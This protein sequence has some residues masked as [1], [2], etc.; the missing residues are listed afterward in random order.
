MFSHGAKWNDGTTKTIRGADPSTIPAVLNADDVAAFKD[1]VGPSTPTSSGVKN[2]EV[3]SISG[4]DQFGAG[5]DSSEWK[6]YL[7]YHGVVDELAVQRQ[8]LKTSLEGLAAEED[9]NKWFHAR[10][11]NR[12]GTLPGFFAIDPDATPADTTEN[13][14]SPWKLTSDSI[15]YWPSHRRPGGYGYNYSWTFDEENMSLM[16]RMLCGAVVDWDTQRYYPEKH[17]YRMYPFWKNLSNYD[18]ASRTFDHNLDTYFP[19]RQTLP[20]ELR[21]RTNATHGHECWGLPEISPWSSKNTYNEGDV[22]YHQGRPWRSTNAGQRAEPPRRNQHEVNNEHKSWSSGWVIDT[23]DRHERRTYG[24][25]GR[26]TIDT[27][28][29]GDIKAHHQDGAKMWEKRENVTVNGTDWTTLYAYC[30]SKASSAPDPRY[31]PLPRQVIGVGYAKKVKLK[32]NISIGKGKNWGKT[33]W[34]SSLDAHQLIAS[35]TWAYDLDGLEKKIYGTSSKVSKIYAWGDSYTKYRE[36]IMGTFIRGRAAKQATQELALMAL[37]DPDLTGGPTFAKS[38]VDAKWVTD[39]L[40]ETTIEHELAVKDTAY[41]V[42]R[43]LAKWGHS[44]GALRAVRYRLI[45]TPHKVEQTGTFGAVDADHVRRFHD[46]IKTIKATGST[47]LLI[48]LEKMEYTD[49]NGNIACLGGTTDVGNGPAPLISAEASDNQ[50]H[51]NTDDYFKQLEQVRKEERSRGDNKNPKP[52]D[53][54]WRDAIGKPSNKNLVSGN[55]GPSGSTRTGRGK[56][57]GK[58]GAYKEGSCTDTS[59]SCS[60]LKNLG[61]KC[62]YYSQDNH[63]EDHDGNPLYVHKH[64]GTIHPGGFDAPDDKK[65]PAGMGKALLEPCDGCGGLRASRTT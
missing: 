34:A 27:G 53:D 20:Q 54:N 9:A 21:P 46:A 60:E 36:G 30:G 3:I 65:L 51:R 42:N 12:D 13:H 32:G 55:P 28:G 47:E 40:G 8:I 56:A 10:F 2:R 62:P 33:G 50:V 31:L 37:Y 57:T 26:M 5:V 58:I 24:A 41:E 38:K 1:A 52:L 17:Q 39:N 29:T 18:L 7:Q 48:F 59:L 25:D 11:M 22:V 63:A 43:H 49:G 6:S 16:H 14:T 44:A 64:N 23:H 15:V 19:S 35:G 45:F 4:T 61:C